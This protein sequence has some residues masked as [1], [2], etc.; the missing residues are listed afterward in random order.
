MYELAT[1]CAVMQRLKLT[2]MCLVPGIFAGAH[3]WFRITQTTEIRHAYGNN[4]TTSA[5]RLFVGVLSASSNRAKRDAVRQTW[6]SHPQLARVVFVINLPKS[7]SLLDTIRQE[8]LDF[9]DVIVGHVTEDYD[10]LAYQSLG[11]FR[12]AYAYKGPITHVL[13]CDDDSYIHVDRLLGYLS[14]LPFQNSWAGTI[15]KSYSPDRNPKSKWFVSRK[16]WPDGRSP[17]KW[18]NGPGYVL[19]SDVVRLLATGGVAKCAPGQLFKL[20][21]IAVGSWLTCL[22]KEQNL[23]LHLASD[24]RFNVVNCKEGDFV[25]HYMKPE[26]MVCMFAQGGRCC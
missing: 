23:T 4:S 26:Q 13:K 2:A 16:E 14:N 9:D 7:E 17:I 11:L 6:G 20:E 5:V 10:N 25:S 15:S 18:S 22:E 3:G 12:T 21:D 24:A 19:T 8:A 1:L